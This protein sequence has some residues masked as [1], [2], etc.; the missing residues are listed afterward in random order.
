[1]K[2]ATHAALPWAAAFVLFF[3]AFNSQPSECQSSAGQA[4]SLDANAPLLFEQNVGQTNSQ[5]RYLARSGRYEIYL[6][7]NAAVLKV[8]GK[9]SDSVLRTTLLKANE[10]APVAGVDEQSGKT[11]YLLGTRSNWKTGVANFAA[12]KYEGVYP[13]IDLKYYS[14]ERQ[15]EYDFD[16]APQADPSMI[17]LT[18][19]GADKIT[20]DEDGS[21]C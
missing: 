15:L 17:A 18:V 5:V 12:V 2:P 16:V 20:T 21:W 11:N 3:F 14:R 1:M 7:Q 10:N 8:A 13:G 4:A 9:K 6:T 19:E